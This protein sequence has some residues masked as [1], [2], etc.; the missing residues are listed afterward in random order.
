M[1]IRE[2]I[3]L[4]KQTKIYRLVLNGELKG[5]RLS[6]YNDDIENLEYF[7]FI[8]QMVQDKKI[9]E[10]L[11][12]HLSSMPVLK[13]IDSGDGYLE[14]ENEREKKIKVKEFLDDDEALSYTKRAIS[15]I[16]EVE[17]CTN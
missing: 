13:L 15:I 5:L 3:N 12:E 2:K 7:D 10:Y 9:Q 4:I 11:E 6:M 1:T 14:T 8:I 16:Q 17:R